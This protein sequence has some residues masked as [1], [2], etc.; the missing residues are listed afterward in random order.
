MDHLIVDNGKIIECKAKAYMYMRMGVNTKVICVSIIGQWERDMPNG[1]GIEW[2][3]NGS[4][5]V[6]K[7]VNG[8]KHG[9]GKLTFVS[10]EV[11]EGDFEFDN[12]NG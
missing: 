7:F 8:E 3:V 10:G 5:Y 9:R 1:D 2:Y 12:F 11:Y 6:G 4:V